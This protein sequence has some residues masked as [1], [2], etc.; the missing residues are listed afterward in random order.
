M[1]NDRRGG[2]ALE[3]PAA[4][5]FDVAVT[6]FVAVFSSI[7]LIGLDWSDQWSS[8][9]FNQSEKYVFWLLKLLRRSIEF[10]ERITWN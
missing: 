9:E 2:T 10:F 8:V 1:P 5:V 3:Q 6:S 7:E 4:A